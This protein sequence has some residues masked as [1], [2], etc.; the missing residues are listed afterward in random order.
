METLSLAAGGRRALPALVGA[1]GTVW[2]PVTHQ[3][4]VQAGGGLTLELGAPTLLRGAWRTTFCL[5]RQPPPP[6]APPTA[7]LSRLQC[8]RLHPG[9]GTDFGRGICPL[10]RPPQPRPSEAARPRAR[11]YTPSRR[12]CPHSQAARHSAR[13]RARTAPRWRTATAWSHSAAAWGHSPAE[14]ASHPVNNSQAQGPGG[15]RARRD[16]RVPSAVRPAMWG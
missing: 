12:C 3:A 13:A 8:R 7:R 11:A 14:T 2:L 1:I 10:S 6:H 5:H 9:R 4:E 16:P 15:A